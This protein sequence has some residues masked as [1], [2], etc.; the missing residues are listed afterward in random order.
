MK[1]VDLSS[2]ETPGYGQELRWQN[3]LLMQAAPDSRLQQMGLG[4]AQVWGG[5][6]WVQ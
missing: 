5:H 4:W 2:H 3:D 1:S 6:S